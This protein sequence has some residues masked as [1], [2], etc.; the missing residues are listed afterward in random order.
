MSLLLVLSIFMKTLLT[1][2]SKEMRS[3]LTWCCRLLND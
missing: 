2:K 1:A 3:D